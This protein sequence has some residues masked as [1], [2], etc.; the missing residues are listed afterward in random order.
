MQK[1]NL[2]DIQDRL[3]KVLLEDTFL[4][5]SFFDKLQIK[6]SL[7]ASS[8]FTE[9]TLLLETTQCKCNDILYFCRVVFA[10]L[11]H[12]TPKEGWLD[13][14]YKYTLFQ[15]FPQ[16]L[17]EEP[18]V[19]YT[20]QVLLYL[21][22]LRTIN[23]FHTKILPRKDDLPYLTLNLLTKKEIEGLSNPN[24]Y[25]KFLNI[26][27]EKYVIEMMQLHQE[28]SKHNTYDHICAVH[29][30]ALKIGRQLFK[31]GLPVD[32]GRVSG[33][34][35]GHDIGKYGC[36]GEEVKRIPYLH[37][38]YTD[39]WFKNNDISDIGHIALN[40][41]TWDLELENLPLESLILIYSDFRAK[42]DT[43]GSKKVMKIYSLQD[44]FH[45]ILDKLDNVNDAKAN[46]YKKVYAKLLDFENYMTNKGINV[47]VLSD[48]VLMPFHKDTV[49]MQGNEIVENLKFH[50]IEHNIHIL[51]KLKTDASLSALIE[52]ARSK[53]NMETLRSYLN[54]FKEYSTYLTQKQKIILINYLYEL[55]VHNE[56]DIRIRAAEV[57]GF[58]IAQFDEEY[59]KEIPEPYEIALP[60]YRG[61]ELFNK[62]I[63]LIIHPPHKT[64]DTHRQWLGYC[65]RTLVGS[66]FIKA[67]PEKWDE[68]K[69]SFISLLKKLDAEDSETQLDLLQVIKFIPWE[70]SNLRTVN[71]LS[72]LLTGALKS[73]DSDIRLVVLDQ[74]DLLLST[75]PY[76]SF[77]A[78]IK[79]AFK[80]TPAAYVPSL[81]ER[82]I[83][84]KIEIKLGILN[85]DELAP[86][87][88]IENQTN[89]ADIFLRNLKS[90]TSWISKKYHIE[91][92]LDYSYHT[93]DA[94]ALYTAMHF[95]NL[96]KVNNKENVRIN[97]GKALLEILN[98][99]TPE[100]KNDIAVELLRGLEIESFVHGA[101]IPEYLGKVILHLNPNELDEMIKDFYYKI[102]RVNTQTVLLTL[103]SIGTAIKFYP[104]YKTRFRENN[105]KYMERLRRMI[106]ILLIG[107]SSYDDLIKQEALAVL[108]NLFASSELSLEAKASIF[109]ISAKKILEFL[110]LKNTNELLFINN[111]ASLNHLYRFMSDYTHCYAAFHFDETPRVAFFSGA[112]DPFSLSHKE[113]AVL[114]R[115]MGFEV[116]LAVDEFSWSK[117][118]IPHKQRHRIVSMSIADEMDI[119]VFPE[120][121][122]INIANNTDLA[123]LKTSFPG[124][125]VY[126]VVGS[127]VI[128]NA[129]SYKKN[130]KESIILDFSH[131]VFNRASKMGLESDLTLY[132]EKLEM[133]RSEVIQLNLPTQYEDI[134]SSLIR[135]CIDKN[136]DISNLIDPLAQKYIYEFGLYLREPQ[137][138]TI[139][140]KSNMVIDSLSKMPRYLIHQLARSF[141]DEKLIYNALAS[142]VS[143]KKANIIIL[144]SDKNR[145]KVL[146]FSAVHRVKSISFF[147][148]FN[149][150]RIS[151][152]VREHSIGQTVIIDGLI[153]T[154]DAPENAIQILFTETM[155]Y[156][157]KNDYTYALYKCAFNNLTSDSVYKTLILQG[158]QRIPRETE[159]PIFEVNMSRPC[160]LN[161]DAEIFIKEPFRSNPAIV[162]AVKRSREKLQL[163]LAKLFPG[164]LVLSF[165]RESLYQSLIQKICDTNCVPFEPKYPKVLRPCMCVPFGQI[166]K[167][168]VVPNT[169]TKTLHT[170]KMF[171]PTVTHF[172]IGP[173]PYHM[174]LENQMKTIQSFDRPI[175]LVD[176]ILDKGYR[177]KAIDPILKKVGIQVEKIIVGICSSRGKELMDLQGREV[178]S[179]YF[180]PNL[181]NWFNESLLYPF[182]GG[183]SIWRGSNPQI[184][185]VPS[186]NLILPYVFPN[187]IRGASVDSIYHLSRVCIEN[188]QDILTTIEKEYQYIHGKML[189][190]KHLGE[191][192]VFSRYP[193]RG[194]G[195]HYDVNLEASHYLKNDLE[196]LVRIEKL[197]I[198]D[199]Q[200]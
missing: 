85:N 124:K 83:K 146:G 109:N 104:I 177:L 52:L 152:Y 4:E 131:I 59:R 184:N 154:D 116:F 38:F 147:N 55:M 97:A 92:M 72:D 189:S 5:K 168:F 173:Y 135:D 174:D 170:E 10:D 24:E 30:I 142:L 193:D 101:Y 43:N 17:D 12:E 106:G 115:N 40:H 66:V 90:A 67:K 185:L 6:Q 179:A 155:S 16:A 62:Y 91:L 169:V 139:L 137:Y 54:I 81:A 78:K 51:N 69:N 86:F 80:A 157:L 172:H 87:E 58:I 64:A 48:K 29:F 145:E 46:R 70:N 148:E 49:L 191:V 121:I 61:L 114:I 63:E 160:I 79:E 32:L 176:D 37:Y 200:Y 122:P 190:L 175:L 28:L 119:H 47:D 7:S 60:E 36:K 149:D 196:Q 166:L 76:R 141:K 117:L 39:L 162:A 108:G 68:F 42:N 188:T 112:F 22:V 50:S 9:L 77:A 105:H 21:H 111:A 14:A 93:S 183:D 128:V 88:E 126:I 99:L 194:N 125:E 74:I 65:L 153:T 192:F 107:L 34:A 171:N 41:S 186:V 164:N 181:R 167:G 140:E 123:K 15:S 127:D 2:S 130:T 45:V 198:N 178:D 8:L 143:D 132:K 134:R 187:F 11:F 98:I 199:N 19:K 103:N 89:M 100:Q 20:S 53:S 44:S 165:A 151:E 144:Y 182:L 159:V 136:R 1:K 120:D 138:K 96:I 35:A 71:F 26:Y 95:C 195:I 150:Q 27:Q 75:Y 73:G 118:T 57:I 158:F 3:T 180:V 113:I 197:L 163:A 31:S 129:S 56:E 161:L 23:A 133:I 25:K 18:D 94:N 13:Y 82:Y 156:C 33:A 110:P 102:K 84:K